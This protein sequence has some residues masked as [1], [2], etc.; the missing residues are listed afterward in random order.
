MYQSMYSYTCVYVCVSVFDFIQ[1]RGVLSLIELFSD[2]LIVLI[3]MK[4]TLFCTES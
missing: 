1:F 4:E 3:E 2:C